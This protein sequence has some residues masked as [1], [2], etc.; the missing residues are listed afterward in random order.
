MIDTKNIAISIPR[1]TEILRGWEHVFC[2]DLPIQHHTVSLKEVNYLFPLW[3]AP[4]WPSTKARA[5]LSTAF[6]RSLTKATK[7]NW[8]EKKSRYM[9]GNSEATKDPDFGPNEVFDFIYAVLHSPA[10]RQRYADLLKSDFAKVPATPSRDLFGKLALLGHQLIELHLL[11]AP[12]GDLTKI[13]YVGPTRPI[14]ERI[15]WADGAI[16]IDAPA[17][18]RGE[19]SVPGHVGFSG[20]PEAAWNFH[21]GG[22]RVC[23]KWLK[24]RRDRRLSAGD[25]A[26]Y[27]KIIF[28]VMETIRLISE[29]DASIEEH[30]GWPGAFVVTEAEA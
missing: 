20:V 23:E 22:Y 8:S 6:V 9:G 27:Q 11:A 15:A 3:L 13:T 25:I 14:V 5:N 1:S 30:G 21:I 19:A 10:Y 29:I 28:A 4:E 16:W 18:R 12:K 24:D 26:Q 2:S 17:A 7:L